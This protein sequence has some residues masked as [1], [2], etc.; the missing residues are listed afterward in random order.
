MHLRCIGRWCLCIYSDILCNV[1]SKKQKIN[2]E[3]M[4][5]VVLITYKLVV[6][7]IS[8]CLYACYICMNH[9]CASITDVINDLLYY[10][11]LHLGC[12][13]CVIEFW[14]WSWIVS[15]ASSSFCTEPYQ[16][17]MISV[18]PFLHR[19]SFLILKALCEM[20]VWVHRL[21]IG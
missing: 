16:L 5:F 14:A 13:F 9:L 2:Q 18:A 8:S 19:S 6:L 4:N 3:L 17:E 15:Q 20:R 21:W 7:I 1:I 10:N 11:M 12:T